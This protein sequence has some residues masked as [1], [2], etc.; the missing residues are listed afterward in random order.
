MD[1]LGK[2]T[3]LPKGPALFAIKSG[4]PLVPTFFIRNDD[5][6][7]TLTL[8]EPV[9]PEFVNGE[10]QISEEVLKSMMKRY[11]GVIENIIRRYPGQWLMFR[12]YWIKD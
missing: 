10:G 6:T 4:A 5:D 3:L 2:R 8:S 7:F 12:P 9:Y 1:F 11:V